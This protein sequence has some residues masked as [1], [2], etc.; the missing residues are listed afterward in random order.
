MAEM[1]ALPVVLPP[2]SFM[3]RQILDRCF[4]AAG[5]T[6]AVVAQMDT[7]TPML[8]YVRRSDVATVTSRMVIADDPTLV[9]VPLEAPSPIR[10]AGILWRTGNVPTPAMRSLASVIRKIG[11]RHV[12]E[13]LGRRSK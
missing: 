2:A 4:A 12:R 1:H 11:E 8:A 5:A 3:T 7:I 13:T 6:P 9:A 10:T